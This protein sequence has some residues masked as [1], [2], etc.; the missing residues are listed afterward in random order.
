VPDLPRLAGTERAPPTP[1]GCEGEKTAE[2][3]QA[4]LLPG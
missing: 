1:P 3:V 2:E 4:R